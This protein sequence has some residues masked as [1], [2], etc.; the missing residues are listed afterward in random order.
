MIIS[1]TGFMGSGKSSVGRVLPALL[2]LPGGP[3]TFIDLDDFIVESEG[4][5]VNEIFA[6][7]G[8]S[9]FRAIETHCLETLVEQYE[10]RNLVL[11]LGGGTAVFNPELV[12]SHTVC[13]YLSASVDTLV[14]RL[15]GDSTRPLL[16]GGDL[17]TK[18]EA[19]Q[20]QREEIYLH[21]A[22]HTIQTDGLTVREIASEIAEIVK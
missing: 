7:E 1:L 14:C 3:F 15:Q 2:S 13:I 10:G 16:R 20:A 9:G 8:E 21:T 6:S 12:H 19:L 22:H 4:M 11:A 17:R 18:I 5:S